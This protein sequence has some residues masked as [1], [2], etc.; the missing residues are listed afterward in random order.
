MRPDNIQANAVTEAK[1]ADGAVTVAKMDSGSA[2]D[3]DVATADGSGGVAF[4]AAT[5]GGG[6]GTATAERTSI[7]LDAADR[8]QA[9]FLSAS[10]D[11]EIVSGYEMEF[12]LFNGGAA[13]DRRGYARMTSDEFLLLTA[14]TA[15]PTDVSEAQGFLVRQTDL[16]GTS[17]SPANVLDLLNI[18]Q[19]ATASDFYY[20]T[21]RSGNFRLQVFKFIAGGPTG[22]DGDPGEGVPAG[23]TDT[24]ILAKASDTDYDTEWVAAPTGGGGGTVSTDAT[25]DGDG[26]AGDPLSLA[27]DAV[28]TA[29]IAASAVHTGKINDDAVTADKLADNAV[30]HDSIADNAVR[31]DNIQASA[32]TTAKMADDAVTVDKM[33][34]GSADDGHVATA[35]G[36]GGVAFEAPTGGG[37]GGGTDDQTAAEVP[38]D[39]TGFTGN[40]A[41]TDDDVQTAL[42]TIDA[43]SLGGGGAGTEQ[44][45]LDQEPVGTVDTF[46]KL[47]IASSGYAYST[48]PE[49]E[50]GVLATG[51][52]E[53][54]DHAMYI[55]AFSFEPNPLSVS[56]GTYYFLTVDYKLRKTVVDPNDAAL[57]VWED[58]PWSEILPTDAGYHGHHDT[59]AEALHHLTMDGDVYHK[60]TTPH[61]GI[62]QVSNFVAGSDEHTDYYSRRLS[63]A[64]EIPEFDPLFVERST[65]PPVTDDSPD[66]VYLSHGHS[67]GA[68]ADAVITVGFTA[69]GVAG[70]ASGDISGALGSTNTPSPLTE[71]FGLGDATDYLIESMYWLNRAGPRRV[72]GDLSQQ[73]PVCAWAIFLKFLAAAHFFVAS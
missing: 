36:S 34:S 55:G 8:A 17:T 71:L 22:G 20:R 15:T 32:V 30:H 21:G 54:F 26:S 13:G 2:A 63:Y 64:D 19:G 62:R 12:V 4:E 7:Y 61:R 25:I 37:G 73:R 53:N 27:D 60:D 56:V 6:G 5:G 59:D 57:S 51:D 65:L 70:Y 28:T 67:V 31:P 38:V 46:G 48:I 72:R 11:E 66:L 39:A 58:A 3:G 40:L 47:Q 52:F 24:Q 69:N 44:R 68:R 16:S 10:F 1:I 18:W 50:L 43:L 45:V 42:D 49:T 35:D 9:T 41:T 23:G 14:Q 29:K 33:N